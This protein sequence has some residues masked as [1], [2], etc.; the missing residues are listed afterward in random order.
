MSSTYDLV[1]DAVVNKK[2]VIAF[3]NGYR[4]EMC[5]HAIGWKKGKE[6][7]L[8][9][10]FAGESSSGLS[11]PEDNWRCIPLDRLDVTEVRIGEWHT[12]DN[13]SRKQT[14]IDRIDVEATVEPS[15]SYLA[16]MSR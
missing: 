16:V 8:F 15:G 10:Q 12:A 4:R 14:C 5:P 3:Y 2:Q 13:H 9:L 1:R 6:Q 7:V 11:R